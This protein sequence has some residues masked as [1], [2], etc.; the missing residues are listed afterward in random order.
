MPDGFIY[1]YKGF[2]TPII[3]GSWFLSTREFLELYFS[4]LSPRYMFNLGDYGA[5]SSFPELA[6]FFL[7]QLPFYIYGL[8]ALIK[9]KINKDFKFLIICL[10]LVC[11]IP[12]AV[13]RDPYTTIRALPLV[14][15]QIIIISLGILDL[16]TK[17]KSKWSKITT[18][19]IF[20]GVVI[21]SLFKLYSSVIIL[22]EHYRAKAW[23]YGWEPVVQEIKNL[24]TTLPII[25]DNARGDAYPQIAFFLK[26]DPIKYQAENIEV[27]LSEYYT[28]MYHKP[29]VHLGNIVTRAINWRNDLLVDQYLIADEL[30]IS[31]QQISDHKLTLVTEIKYPEGNPAYRII[32]TNPEFTKKEQLLRSRK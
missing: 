12:A 27:S 10:L 2:L 5:R 29:E 31:L 1:N 7:W 15:P 21:Y 3:N 11:P 26:Y 20:I 17:L 23:D 6:T 14:I 30:G 8:W 9:N 4:Y 24:N 18:I 32:K 28:N 19:I 25:V 16:F 22:N 13:T